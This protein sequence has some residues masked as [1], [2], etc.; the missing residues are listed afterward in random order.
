MEQTELLRWKRQGFRAGCPQSPPGRWCEQ[1]A[2]TFCGGDNY[3]SLS[4]RTARTCLGGRRPSRVRLL[5]GNSCC[6]YICFRRRSRRRSVKWSAC[7][8]RSHAASV[9]QLTRG[10]YKSRVKIGFIL[11]LWNVFEVCVCI[12]GRREISTAEHQTI[13]KSKTK[14]II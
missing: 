10:E 7:R 14:Y 1:Y 9:D 12:W 11:K 8:C 5:L 4:P 6:L 13:Y 3:G 2:L